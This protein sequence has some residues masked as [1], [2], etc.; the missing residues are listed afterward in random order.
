MS[1]G[2]RVSKYGGGMVNNPIKPVASS[3]LGNIHPTCIQCALA[4]NGSLDDHFHFQKESLSIQ[5]NEENTIH[6]N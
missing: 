1:D 5:V 4:F 2:L 3:Y 6:L